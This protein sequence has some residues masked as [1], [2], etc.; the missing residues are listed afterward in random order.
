MVL[1]YEAAVNL[2]KSM[3]MVAYI[4]LREHVCGIL[5]QQEGDAMIL[6]EKA[7]G[8]ENSLHYLLKKLVGPKDPSQAMTAGNAAIFA[9]I[10]SGINIHMADFM[11][12]FR[13]QIRPQPTSFPPLEIE[14][15][16]VMLWLH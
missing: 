6:R 3:V 4:E 12:S 2:R 10:G 1:E 13:C 5:C 16:L 7:P 11:A 9:R 14:Q 15:F 8:W